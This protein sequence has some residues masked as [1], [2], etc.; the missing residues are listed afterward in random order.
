LLDRLLAESTKQ[1]S[2]PKG[3]LDKQE[4]KSLKFSKDWQKNKKSEKQKPLQ[5]LEELNF[6]ENNN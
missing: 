6:K 3:L 4:I 1:E 5:H 2:K